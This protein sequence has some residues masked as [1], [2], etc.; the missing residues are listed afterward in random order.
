MDSTNKNNIITKT[1]EKIDKVKDQMHQN[2][3]ILLE[4]QVRLESV[5]LKSQELV[6]SAGI[7]AQTSKDLKRRIWWKNMKIKI[8]I[9]LS[10]IGVIA[11]IAGICVGLTKSKN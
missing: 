9:G 5:D 6:Q 8:F 10:C 4:N 11:I 3:N 7:F 1:N 2:I